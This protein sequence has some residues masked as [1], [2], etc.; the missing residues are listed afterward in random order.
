MVMQK[1]NAAAVDVVDL[2]SVH[3]I[4]TPSTYAKQCA[5][6]LLSK[7]K[8]RKIADEETVQIYIPRPADEHTTIDIV[9]TAGPKGPAAA[10]SAARSKVLDVLKT[11]PP[12]VFD[13]VEIDQLL[14]RFLIGRKGAKIQTFE[15]KN[16]VQVVFPPAA[17]GEGEDK[18]ITLIYVGSDLSSAPRTLSEVKEEILKLAKEA[19]D[20]STST[21]TIPAKLHRFIIGPSGTTLNALIGTGDERIVN[22]KFGSSAAPGAKTADSKNEDEVV[23]RGPSD[24]VK[25]VVKEIERIAEEAKNDEIVNSYV[26]PVCHGLYIGCPAEMTFLTDCRVRYRATLRFTYCR[27]GRCG[28]TKAS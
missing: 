16:K 6:Y 22:V 23:V 5:R 11:L 24:E 28:C 25:K 8:L 2:G 17:V 18:Q 1:A 21:L 4:N 7:A 26:C 10:V 12:S 19:A 9:A 14:H 27:K 20:I 15:E 3:G 13:T